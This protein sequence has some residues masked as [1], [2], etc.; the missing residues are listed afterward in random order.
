MEEKISVGDV[1]TRNFTHVK[2][3]TSILDC[4]KKM[5]KNRVGSIIIKDENKL[6]GIITEKDII[7]ALTKKNGSNLDKIQAK[8][9]ATKKIHIIKP[10]ANLKEALS[11]MNKYKIRRMP[12]LSNK[13]IIG[14]I[15]LKDIV[16][17]IP[18]VFEGSREFE[19]IKEEEEK[20]KR[21]ES[22][23]KGRFIESLC[24]ECG[25]FDILG[26]VDGMMI[27]ESCRDEM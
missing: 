13:K 5:I 19:K 15:T 16:K 24:E 22:A 17:F 27:C 8:D 25:N 7:W 26:K 20:I 4:A 12:V 9:V 21:S 14:Y 1:M 2:P 11:K 18:D 3:D 23:V 6:H 10:E